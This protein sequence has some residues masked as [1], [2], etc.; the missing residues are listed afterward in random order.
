MPETGLIS[1]ALGALAALVAVLA[2]LW[3]AVR[4]AERLQPRPRAGRRLA[5]AEML[6]LDS[7]RRLTLA[8]VDGREVLLLTGGP[9]DLVVGW[10]P[11]SPDR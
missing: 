6:A 1:T 10:L 9:Q 3:L 8:R 7:R 11:P 5:V 2:A 4:L